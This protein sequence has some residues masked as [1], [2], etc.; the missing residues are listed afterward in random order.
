MPHM[1]VGGS[2]GSGNVFLFTMLASMLMSHPN[3]KDLQLVLS[4]SK[5]E[6]FIHFE[7]LPHLYNGGPFPM[8]I[9]AT[10][11]IKMRILRNRTRGKL[12]S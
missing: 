1:L 10:E 8:R 5:V 7:G 6:D 3:P 9:E 2:T 12:V 4:S 11:V